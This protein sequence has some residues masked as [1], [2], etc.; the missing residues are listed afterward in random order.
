MFKNLN[1][2]MS[3]FDVGKEKLAEILNIAISTIYNKLSTGGFTTVE[4]CA[5]RDYFNVNFGTSFTIDYLFSTE[6]IAV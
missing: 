6:P 2:E 3:R 1:A 4:A 5:I